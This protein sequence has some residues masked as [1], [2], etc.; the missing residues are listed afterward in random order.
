MSYTW[1]VFDKYKE[2]FLMGEL[3]WNFQDFETYEGK[4]PAFITLVHVQCIMWNSH[5][6]LTFTLHTHIHTTHSHS[7]Y[8]H[9]HIHTTHSHSHYTHSAPTHRVWSRRREQEGYPDTTET[10]EGGSKTSEE[11]LPL[12]G[13]RYGGRGLHRPR[14]AGTHTEEGLR[15]LIILQYYCYSYNYYMLVSTV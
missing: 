14:P 11:A 15:S 3:I 13:C 12:S 7:H 6:T 1:S 9:I 8:T 2:Q 5:Y 4:E 10:A